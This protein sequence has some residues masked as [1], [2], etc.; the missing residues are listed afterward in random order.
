MIWECTKALPF[1]SGEV[2]PVVVPVGVE[3]VG[4]AVSDRVIVD[5]VVQIPELGERIGVR[6]GFDLMSA[7]Q[8]CTQAP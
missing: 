8:V 5:L 6:E 3:L 1:M 7:I 4:C 2:T